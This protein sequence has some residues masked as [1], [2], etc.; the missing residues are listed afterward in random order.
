M[1]RVPLNSPRQ[2]SQIS[3]G[4]SC[5]GQDMRQARFA[6]PVLSTYGVDEVVGHLPEP[7]DR[8]RRGSAGGTWRADDHLLSI[9]PPVY[10][11][12][13]TGQVIGRDRKTSWPFHDDRDPSLHVYDDAD[14]GWVCFGC[15]RG[16]RI[17]D[18][19]RHLWGNRAARQGLLGRHTSSP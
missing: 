13:L 1:L 19:G 15:R 2:G 14:A 11:E 16:G 12:A 17:I 4:L 9:A 6:L 10:I 5:R 8:T 3:D 18:F 7:V